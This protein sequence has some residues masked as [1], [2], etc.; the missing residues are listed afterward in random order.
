MPSS[1]SAAIDGRIEARD[2]LPGQ[3]ELPR[4]AVAGRDPQGMIDEIEVD[5]KGSRAIRNRRRRQ[6]ARGDIER[7]MPGMIEPGRRASAGSC[8][9]SG[10]TAAASHRCHA[11]PRSAIPATGLAIMLLMPEPCACRRAGIRRPS[12]IPHAALRFGAFRAAARSARGA[13][14][15]AAPPAPRNRLQRISHHLSH[16]KNFDHSDAHR[17]RE[18]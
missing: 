4:C 1:A 3:R 10:S 7:D 6:P 12:R 13:E 15:A 14:Q 17:P 8:R 18:R 5:L 16:E 2:R 9:R 11:T